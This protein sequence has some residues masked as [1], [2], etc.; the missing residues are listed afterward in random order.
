MGVSV[1][2]IVEDTAAMRKKNDNNMKM[3]E[4]DIMINSIDLTFK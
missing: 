1:E 4:L 3:M 2:I